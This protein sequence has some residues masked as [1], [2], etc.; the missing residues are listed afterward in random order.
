MTT[1]PSPADQPAPAAADAGTLCAAFQATAARRGDAIALRT[2]EGAE[3]TW[4]E[5]ADRV[6]ALAAGLAAHGIGR[7]DTVA[8]MLTNRSEGHLVDT[9]ALHLGATPFSIY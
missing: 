4:K 3:I 9:A 7:G 5:Y 2:P 1:L 6:R 8:I